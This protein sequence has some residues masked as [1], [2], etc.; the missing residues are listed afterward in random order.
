MGLSVQ[1]SIDLN[2]KN[3][4][5]AIAAA[6][7]H[8]TLTPAN[9]RSSANKESVDLIFGITQVLTPTTLLTANVGIGEVTGFISD[10]YKVAEVNGSLTYE[11]R[12]DSKTK[13]I[14]YI[15]VDQ[16]ITPLNAS[17][18]VGMRY[19]TDSF[20]I[21]AE[22][23][24]LA[25]FQKVGEH[26]IVSPSFRYYMQSAASF[27]DV[28]FTGSPDFYSSDYRV[29]A[30]NATAYGLTVIWMPTPRLTLDA[31]IERYQQTGTDGQTDP[32]FYPS[33]TLFMVGARWAL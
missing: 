17:L 31:G 4:T 21:D 13:E 6:V 20:G 3:T 23:F 9:G 22:T 7:T 8:D 28:R 14:A 25:W 10:P 5:L 32:E 24:S 11:K 26:W 30:F 2:R 18:E 19:Y 16:F 33:A 15:G 1:D 29:S 27:Y 12:P